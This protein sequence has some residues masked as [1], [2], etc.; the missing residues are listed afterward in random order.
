MSVGVLRL[1][2]D[3]Q[4]LIHLSS[5]DVIH[6]FSI[7]EFR[8]KQDAIPGMRVPTHF[9][10]TLTTEEFRTEVGDKFR[11]FEIVCAQLCGLGHFRMKGTVIVEEE[12]KILEWIQS[13]QRP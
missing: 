11:S 7:P 6:S 8:V 13:Q 9:T 1:P 2:V 10:P 5:K 3:R 4:A 12:E